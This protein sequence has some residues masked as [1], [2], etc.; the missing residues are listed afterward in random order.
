MDLANALSADTEIVTNLSEKL[1]LGSSAEDCA[2]SLSSE[3]AEVE[4]R[5]YGALSSVTRSSFGVS[6]SPSSVVKTGASTDTALPGAPPFGL[7][8][9]RICPLIQY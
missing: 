2:F 8:C 6:V 5:Y 1:S 3:G 4:S 7:N 9:S